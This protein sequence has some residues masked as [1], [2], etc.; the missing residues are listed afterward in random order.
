MSNKEL[1]LFVFEGSSAEPKYVS[2]LEKNF[3]GERISI[4]CVYEADI[5]QLYETMKK[6]D[7]AVDIVSVLKHR[8][9]RNADILK[10][11]NNDS[12]AYTYLFFDYDGHST[13]ADD[14]KIAE[15]LEFFDNETENGLLYISYPMVEAIRHYKD[16]ASFKDLV[17]KCKRGK[18]VEEM[19]C[20]YSND[21]ES[22]SECLREPHYK[23]ISASSNK[24]ELNYIST[25]DYDVWKE[26]ILANV[27]KMNYLVNNSFS[28]SDD[29]E[30][31]RT[32]FRRQYEKFINHKC[33]MVAVLSSFPIY[34]LD[35]YGVQ[36]LKN[37]LVLNLSC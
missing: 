24:S 10:D 3:L 15:M 11:Y 6:S 17:V 30:T 36:E 4:K 26:L 27:F 22:V 23:T 14:A 28:M 29:V 8:S 5:Y 31:Q 1:Q 16:M 35:Y 33:P 2:S 9:K 13:M 21:C 34:V 32:I 25:Y 12:F 20:S 37:K 18:D 19:K 7:F